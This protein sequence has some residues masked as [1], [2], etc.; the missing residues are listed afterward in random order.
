MCDTLIYTEKHNSPGILL[1]ID[2]E[3]AFDSVS[4][5]FIEKKVLIFL[6]L[7]QT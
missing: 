4:R 5:S 3:K 2:F 7:V 6:T 1:M